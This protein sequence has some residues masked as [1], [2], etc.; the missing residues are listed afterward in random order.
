MYYLDAAAAVFL[1][2]SAAFMNTQNFQSALVFR[3]L[4]TLFG[5]ALAFQAFAHFMKW[6]T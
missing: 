6:P 4:P 2:S 3:V 5:V 1:L